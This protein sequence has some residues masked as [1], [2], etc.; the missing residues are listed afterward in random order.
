M[1][2]KPEVFLVLTLSVCGMLYA[3]LG[4]GLSPFT[5]QADW[6]QGCCITSGNC[7]GNKICYTYGFPQGWGPCGN[8]IGEDQQGNAIMIEAA[9]YCN[10]RLNPSW[11]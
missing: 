6:D 3:V 1:K 8:I 5:V 4:S 2:K 7:G 11:E 9:G 10:S